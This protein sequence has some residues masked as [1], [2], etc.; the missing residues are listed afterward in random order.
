MN[1]PFLNSNYAFKWKY[2]L[3]YS[4][5]REGHVLSTCLIPFGSEC[6]AVYSLMTEIKKCRN[7]SCRDLHFYQPVL[8]IVSK[9]DLNIDKHK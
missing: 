9:K 6:I 7:I 4:V 5:F 1:S 8:L 3:V 2:Q